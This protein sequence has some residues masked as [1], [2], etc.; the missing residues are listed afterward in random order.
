MFKKNKN[1]KKANDFNYLR[2]NLIYIYNK[3]N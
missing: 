1:N 3:D 2:S